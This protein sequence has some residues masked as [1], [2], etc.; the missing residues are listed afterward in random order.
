MY[1]SDSNQILPVHGA[2]THNTSDWNDLDQTNVLAVV[3]IILTITLG[4]LAR[5]KKKP[6]PQ[7]ARRHKLCGVL[8]LV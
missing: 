4:H 7:M 3:S 6:M 5:V 8:T 2:C 1:C